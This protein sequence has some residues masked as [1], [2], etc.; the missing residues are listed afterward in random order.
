[1][2]TRGLESFLN[3]AFPGCPSRAERISDIRR[4]E[5]GTTWEVVDKLTGQVVY[6]NPIRDDCVDWEIAHYEGLIEKQPQLLEQ[7]FT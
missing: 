2:A 5:D 4:S 3:D 1:M 6:Q 7:L